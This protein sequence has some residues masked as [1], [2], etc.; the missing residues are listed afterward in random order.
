MAAARKI[1]YNPQA[2]AVNQAVGGN[3]DEPSLTPCDSADID[4]AHPQVLRN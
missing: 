1:P 3:A 2:G 4:G